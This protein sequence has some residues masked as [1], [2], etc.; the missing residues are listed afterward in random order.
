MQEPLASPRT[1]SACP[2]KGRFCLRVNSLL[3]PL[4]WVLSKF[5]LFPKRDK[6]SWGAAFQAKR[7]RLS[8]GFENPAV[9]EPGGPAGGGGLGL[10]KWVLRSHESGC[11]GTAV[12]RAGLPLGVLVLSSSSERCSQL[13]RLRTGRP[14]VQPHPLSHCTEGQL[15]ARGGK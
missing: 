6:G 11:S 1:S 7:Q 12:P 5:A 15:E 13:Q 2:P 3:V 9:S 8:S 4:F 14:L 10:A